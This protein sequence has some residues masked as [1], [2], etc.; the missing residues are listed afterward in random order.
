[1]NS[2]KTVVDAVNLFK[3]EFPSMGWPER[4]S[5]RYC[6]L[7]ALCD[8]R[9]PGD[10]YKKGL[11]YKGGTCFNRDLFA[12][13]CT[14]EEFNQCVKEMSHHAGKFEY[15]QYIE[16]ENEK[17][18]PVNPVGLLKFTPEIKLTH[19]QPEVGMLA[20]IEFNCPDMGLMVIDFTLKFETDAEYVG[21][22]KGGFAVI[23]EKEEFIAW[24]ATDERSELDIAMDK[25]KKSQAICCEVEI[26]EKQDELESDFT[27]K[28]MIKFMQDNN[29]L[30]EIKL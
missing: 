3:G 12:L 30:S 17:L 29:M 16:H 19:K 26:K 23:I 9:E 13:I 10:C 28:G 8:S 4:D 15:M 11:L 22:D 5:N 27:I 25:A 20:R 7:I 14:A 1:M 6:I 2:K 21:L 24:H 18:E